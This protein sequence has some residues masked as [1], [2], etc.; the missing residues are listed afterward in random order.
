[1]E[2]FK[3]ALVVCHSCFERACRSH[4]QGQDILTL[5]DAMNTVHKQWLKVTDIVKH[6]IRV[7]T[8]TTQQQNPKILQ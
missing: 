3:G 7:K 1:M 6:P 5:D 8:S 4:L 2:W